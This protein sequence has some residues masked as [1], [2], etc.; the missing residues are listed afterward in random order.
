ML[1][2]KDQVSEWAMKGYA[3]LLEEAFILDIGIIIPSF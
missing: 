2:Q 3:R 1:L